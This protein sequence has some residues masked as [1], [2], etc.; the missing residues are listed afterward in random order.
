[1]SPY[2]SFSALLFL[3]FFSF[4]SHFLLTNVSVYSNVSTRSND[5]DAI[6]ELAAVL[7]KIE[8]RVLIEDFLVSILTENEIN[9]IHSRW[10][11][12]K[13]LDQGVSQRTIARKLGLSLCKITRGSK[14]L[15]KKNSAFKKVIREY[16]P[17][18]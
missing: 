3:Q 16:L 11:L 7:A 9:E 5:M 1:M 8:D 12:V 15:K 6:K 2:P 17:G 18:I 13:L 14:E 4:F 10:D